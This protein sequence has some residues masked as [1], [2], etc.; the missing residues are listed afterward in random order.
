MDPESRGARNLRESDSPADARAV[1]A[2]RKPQEAHVRSA[3]PA[4]FQGRAHPHGA[5]CAALAHAHERPYIPNEPGGRAGGENGA[6]AC[7]AGNE[8]DSH[9]L[10]DQ[11]F[12]G[13]DLRVFRSSEAQSILQRF[14]PAKRARRNR[15]HPVRRSFLVFRKGERRPPGGARGADQGE[16][17][18]RRRGQFHQFKKPGHR[19]ERASDQADSEHLPERAA[20]FSIQP[21]PAH[22]I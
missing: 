22:D 14:A 1:G 20:S 13:R 12:A 3:L 6:A 19:P 18:V 7:A 17:P 4:G 15:G 5:Q 2:G 21:R 11:R 8:R 16:D 10:Y 9:Y